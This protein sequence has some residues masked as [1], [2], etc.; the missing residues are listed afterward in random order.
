MPDRQRAADS[1]QGDE[2]ADQ[3]PEAVRDA[4]GDERQAQGAEEVAPVLVDLAEVPLVAAGPKNAHQD[5]RDGHRDADPDREASSPH[6]SR[7][8]GFWPAQIADLCVARRRRLALES[9]SSSLL[10]LDDLCSARRPSWFTGVRPFAAQ[11]PSLEGCAA[12]APTWPRIMR[13]SAS[14]P[15]ACRSASGGWRRSV[16]PSAPSRET[17]SRC[18]TARSRRAA[19][20]RRRAQTSP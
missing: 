6:Y 7:P 12:V 4:C 11:S 3:E 9:A 1:R 13:A 20:P 8:R 5:G 14:H 15:A 10:D 2:D 16:H 19:W 17:G 18:A